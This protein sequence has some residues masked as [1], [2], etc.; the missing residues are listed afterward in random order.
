MEGDACSSCPNTDKCREVWAEE[1]N[2]P[3]TPGG[4]AICSGVAFLLPLAIAI[5]SGA[6]GR[7]YGLSENKIILIS[8]GGLIGGGVI[9]AAIVTLLKKRF[10]RPSCPVGDASIAAGENI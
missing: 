3:L 7:A 8:V 4:L 1:N 9:A 10:G 5:M 6:G 2:G